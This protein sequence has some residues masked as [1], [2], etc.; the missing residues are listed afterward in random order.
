MLK[1]FEGKDTLVWRVRVRLGRAHSSSDI[2]V[3]MAVVM[4]SVVAFYRCR[5]ISH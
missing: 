5:V 3:V 2:S 1:I 4:Y